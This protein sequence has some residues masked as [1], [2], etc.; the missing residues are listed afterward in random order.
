M[1]FLS[2]VGV[3][4][5]VGICVACVDGQDVSTSTPAPPGHDRDDLVDESLHPGGGQYAECPELLPREQQ[6]VEVTYAVRQRHEHRVLAEQPL[7][8]VVP[9]EVVVHLVEHLLLRAALV[10][11]PYDLLLGHVPLVGQ[12]GAFHVHVVAPFL[13]AVELRAL[14]LPL[15][16]HHEAAVRALAVVPVE[17][18][19]EDLRLQVA[20]D[21]LAPLAAGVLELIPQ[22]AAHLSPDEDALAVLQQE[23]DDILLVGTAVHA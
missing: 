19:G 10:V 8:Q 7:G 12:Y 11:E 3:K 9:A 23:L 21:G 15:A 18:Q 2:V 16:L 13:E 17:G 14:L 4:R 6:P 1:F 5:F 22:A 20:H